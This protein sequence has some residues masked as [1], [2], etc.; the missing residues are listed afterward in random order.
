MASGS[1]AFVG[2]C[3]DLSLHLLKGAETWRGSRR[4][5]AHSTAA[6]P[7]RLGPCSAS[8]EAEFTLRGWGAVSEEHR[9]LSHG[10]AH[11]LCLA[12][13]KPGWASALP[14]GRGGPS[15][16]GSGLSSPVRWGRTPGRTSL[17]VGLCLSPAAARQPVHHALCGPEFPPVCFVTAE[18]V[19]VW[20]CCL[21]SEGAFA[22][23]FLL[24]FL[25]IS[26]FE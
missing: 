5:R 14:D 10:G 17:D 7:P 4:W 6:S 21:S 9:A 12:V 11:R 1:R 22:S 2:S 15:A 23:C 16:L 13:E 20:T 18:L 24:I 25:C 3:C 19:L 8:E 26:P